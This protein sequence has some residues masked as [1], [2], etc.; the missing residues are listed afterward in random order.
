[1]LT[2]MTVQSLG[3]VEGGDRW[4]FGGSLPLSPQPSSSSALRPFLPLSWFLLSARLV[5]QW[6]ATASFYSGLFCLVHQLFQGS[7]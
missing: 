5:Q 6:V 3:K 2:P 4:F 1:M 7:S